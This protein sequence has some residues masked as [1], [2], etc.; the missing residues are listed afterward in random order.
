MNFCRQTNWTVCPATDF[1][2]NVVRSKTIQFPYC[3]TEVKF[4][5]NKDNFLVWNKT[6]GEDGKEVCNR[7]VACSLLKLGILEK[8]VIAS[9]FHSGLYSGIFLW[10]K[11]CH[12]SY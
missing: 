11:R 8:N 10:E 9:L 12:M 6:N 4:D 1:K 3:V 2:I 7:G 5:S